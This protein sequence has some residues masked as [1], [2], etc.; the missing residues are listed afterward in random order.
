LTKD[1][2]E[3]NEI[4]INNEKGL[5]KY[6]EKKYFNRMP[7]IMKNKVFKS[8]WKLAF[9]LPNDKKCTINRK[10]NTMA[11]V[12]LVK[13]SQESILEF[14]K[15]D[16]SIFTVSI[17]KNCGEHL[18]WFL[19]KYPNIYKILD[20]SIKDKINIAISKDVNIKALSW[21]IEGDLLKHL[22]IIK[23]SCSNIDKDATKYVY[24]CY[25]DNGY[26]TQFIDACIFMFSKSISFDNSNEMFYKFVNPYLKK[27][28]YEQLKLLVNGINENSQIYGRR[29]HESTCADIYKVAKGKLSKDFKFEDYPNFKIF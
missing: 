7:Q 2:D 6:L 15:A 23:L 3:N 10:I 27:M 11:L 14:I 12:V 21:F 4:Y 20:E 26:E 9:N 24:N 28:N 22:E 25:Y 18:I 19:S 8:L 16:N 5:E 29:E 13:K 1:L 17:N